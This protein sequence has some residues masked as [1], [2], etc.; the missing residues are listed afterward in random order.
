MNEQLLNHVI[1]EPTAPLSD[2]SSRTPLVVVC[3][4]LG[5]SHRGWL[6][7]VPYLNLPH[8][9]FAVLDAPFPYYDGFSWFRIPGLTDPSHGPQDFLTDFTHSRRAL[10]HFL[11]QLMQS[12]GI[13]SDRVLLVGFSQ[14]CQMVVAQALRSDQAYAGTIGI[15]G[16]LGD[17]QDYP[18]AFGA[19]VAS[20][21]LLITHGQFD[22]LLP[23]DYS[24]EQFTHLRD[25]CAVQ[26]EWREYAKDHSVDPQQELVEIRQWIQDRLA[27]P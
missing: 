23:I 15:S 18:M 20:Q 10:N 2:D 8:C 1:V 13:S 26:L 12:R 4:G 3:H 24:R 9:A 27:T 5:D 11:E 25:E 19:A 21:R 14:G 7:V 22:P 6:G 17:L 16:R